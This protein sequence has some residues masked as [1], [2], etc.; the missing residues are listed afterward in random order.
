MERMPIIFVGHGTPMNA[1]ENNEFTRGWEEM[2]RGFPKP[3]AILMISAHWFT[4]GT[5]TNDVISPKMVYDMYGFPKELY[6]VRYPAP[7][8]PEIAKRLKE[9]LPGI[10]N[11][12]NTWGFDHGAWS[13]L[14]HMFPKADIPVIQLSID[15]RKALIDYIAMG[16]SLC[17]LRD[18]GVLIIGS[19]N[20]AHNLRYVDWNQNGG[21]LWADQ[22]D[23]AVKDAILDHQLAKLADPDLLPGGNLSVP[24]ADHYAPLL[25]VLG[26]SLPGDQIKIY[27]EKR[28]LGSLSMTSYRIG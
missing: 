5:F 15:G 24:S 8:S 23:K 28:V 21:Y 17:T 3:K 4:R 10:V 2:A 6:Q 20:V 26:A 1:I 16:K 11:V 18:E 19:G 7:G 25:F 22:F 13:V 9:L 27:N 12:D 14:V